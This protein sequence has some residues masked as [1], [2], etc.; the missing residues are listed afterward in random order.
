MKM[1]QTECSETSVFKLQTP[2]YYPKE[3]IQRFVC[4]YK[5]GNSAKIYD[6]VREKNYAELLLKNNNSMY[7]YYRAGLTAQG[8]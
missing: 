3:S 6:Y 5:H 8:Q 1:E 4:S 7:I 2:G